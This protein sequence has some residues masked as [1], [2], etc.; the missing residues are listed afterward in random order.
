MITSFSFKDGSPLHWSISLENLW[1]LYISFLLLIAH[2]IWVSESKDYVYMFQCFIIN[3][4]KL[5]LKHLHHFIS[6]QIPV[7][8]DL[9]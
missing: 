2:I 9:F 5:H 1:Y 6:Q 7:D 3:V 8:P 4:F